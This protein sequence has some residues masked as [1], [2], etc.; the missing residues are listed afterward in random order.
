[1]APIFQWAGSL[2]FLLIES[3]YVPQILKL[4]Q[5]KEAEEFSVLFPSA[6][7]LGRIFAVTY[8]LA[9]GDQVFVWGLALGI[10]LRIILLSQVVWYRARRRMAKRLEEEAVAI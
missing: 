10:T 3:S 6:N 1:M 2:G 7:L 4:F 5:L 8:S 9:K